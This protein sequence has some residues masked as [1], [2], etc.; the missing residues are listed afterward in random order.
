MST[1]PRCGFEEVAAR[2]LGTV[3]LPLLLEA[4]AGTV[5]AWLA[6]RQRLALM[7]LAS[8]GSVADDAGGSRAGAAQN[9]A[10]DGN[11]AGGAGA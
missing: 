4:L 9:A 10:A 1:R 3:P 7:R 6:V 5:V 2:Q 8:R 11:A